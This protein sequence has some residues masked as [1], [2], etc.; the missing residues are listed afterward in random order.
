MQQKTEHGIILWREKIVFSKS[1][2]LHSLDHMYKKLT[3][4]DPQTKL[5]RKTILIQV[6]VRERDNKKIAYIFLRKKKTQ[7]KN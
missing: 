3:G 5:N 7:T 4:N 1:N 2:V 6:N